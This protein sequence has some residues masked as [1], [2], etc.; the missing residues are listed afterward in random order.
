MVDIIVTA[1]ME[2]AHTGLPGD[3]RVY[4]LEVVEAGSIR[5]REIM[6]DPRVKTKNR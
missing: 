4:V 2:H 3:G 1:I 5:S 6:V